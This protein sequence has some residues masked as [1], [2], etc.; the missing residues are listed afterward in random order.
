MV[1]RRAARCKARPGCRP[2]DDR[3]VSATDSVMSPTALAYQAGMFC[4]LALVSAVTVRLMIGARVMDTPDARK[5]HL[6]PTPKGGGVGIVVAF[7]VGMAALHA[8]GELAR[9]AE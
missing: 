7:L 2:A 9:L 1:G 3:P 8:Q 4:V 6:R 5:S